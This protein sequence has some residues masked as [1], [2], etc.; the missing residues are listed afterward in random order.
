M[1]NV[2]IISS[3]LGYHCTRV[4]LQNF[5]NHN[6]TYPEQKPHFHEDLWLNGAKMILSVL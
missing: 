2:D 3:K 1:V 4:A 5:L 6:F